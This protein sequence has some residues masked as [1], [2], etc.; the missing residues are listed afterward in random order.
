M[1]RQWSFR[2]V[3]TNDDPLASHQ[4]D[5]CYF[6]RHLVKKNVLIFVLFFCNFITGWPIRHKVTR[7]SSLGVVGA[8][9]EAVIY[10]EIHTINSFSVTCVFIKKTTKKKQTVGRQKDLNVRRK[11]WHIYDNS[12]P[13]HFLYLSS[14][15][16]MMQL[17]EQ[18]FHLAALCD[19]GV[20]LNTAI[21]LHKI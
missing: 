2:V 6:E 13:P 1:F 17:G 11:V 7:Y 15:L 19:W 8:S 14:P 18:I 9:G 10:P 5:E 12:P 16:V 4:F 3:L 21:S 20:C